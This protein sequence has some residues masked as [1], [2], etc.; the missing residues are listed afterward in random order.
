MLRQMVAPHEALL[1]LT[2]LET[3]VSC[4]CACMPLELIAPCEPLPTED[5]GADEGPLPG[6]EPHVSPQQR[7]LPKR[8][9]TARNMTDVLPLTHLT[10]PLV[11]VFTVGTGTGHPPF[12]L[13]G[14]RG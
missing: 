14:P 11:C 12:L 6:V 4:V 10:G 8:L 2:A 5:P 13:T 9:F 7:R 3:F 1:T